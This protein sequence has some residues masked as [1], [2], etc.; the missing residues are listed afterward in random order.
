MCFHNLNKHVAKGLVRLLLFSD[1][2]VDENTKPP[3]KGYVIKKMCVPKPG[4][5]CPGTSTTQA[6]VVPTSSHLHH[7]ANTEQLLPLSFPFKSA[8]LKKNNW[9][10]AFSLSVRTHML[11]SIPFRA[12]PHAMFNPIQSR[13]YSEDFKVEHRDSLRPRHSLLSQDLLCCQFT[14]HCWHQST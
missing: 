9:S 11:C 7:D 3:P 2:V 6:E 5:I 13:R 12:H 14:T 8:P 4:F 10:D 1:L